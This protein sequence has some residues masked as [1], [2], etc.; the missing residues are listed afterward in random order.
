MTT[1]AVFRKSRG[2]PAAPGGVESIAG[3]RDLVRIGRGGFS[4]VYRAHQDELDRTVA[5]K[6]LS[7]E[8]LD[9]ALRRRFLREVKLTSRLTGHPNVVT[10]LDSGATRA[11]RPYLAMEYFERGSLHDRLVASGP[12]PLAEVLRVGVKVAGALAAAHAEGVLHRDVKPQNILLSRYGEPALADF[13]TARLT[14]AA[15]VSAHTEAL[16]PHHAAPEL[17]QGEQPTPRS[18]IYSLGSTLYH[19]LAGHPPYQVEQGGIAA[20]L[21]KILNDEPPAVPSREA[22]LSAVKVL[23]TAMAKNPADRFADAWA[24]AHALQALQASLSLPVTELG[25]GPS[26]APTSRPTLMSGLSTGMESTHSIELPTDPPDAWLPQRPESLL[27]TDWAQAAQAAPSPEP[28]SPPATSLS[29]PP[30]PS[31]PPPTPVT[32]VTPSRQAGPRAPAP[33][34]L[35][36]PARSRWRVPIVVAIAALV[37]IGLSIVAVLHPAGGRTDAGPTPTGQP[38]AVPSGPDPSD[39]SWARPSDLTT[40][41][42]GAI[43][44]LTWRLATGT[45]RY[46][47]A[48][49][50]E[51]ATPGSPAI[52]LLDP[53][54]T[55]HTANGLDPS[56]GY[57]FLVGPVLRLGSGGR[58]AT[59]AWVS[60][61]ACLRGAQPG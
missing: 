6:V 50:Q 7:V 20:L 24:F 51:P 22:P 43:V 56:K 8:F 27:P 1:V 57:C 18:D 38:T 55:S 11:G 10:V 2:E 19:L 16:T 34:T 46:Y 49:Q 41:D 29:V 21:V 9:A 52:T 53:G 30:A 42:D 25:G 5:V 45:Q 26:A 59:I 4:V 33:S 28:S 17:L 12:L 35:P 60:E 13:G 58:P 23:R 44:R 48:F 31:P 37:L 54:T 40:V 3:Y 61:P 39:T 14:E 32:P 15:E 47:V 36:V